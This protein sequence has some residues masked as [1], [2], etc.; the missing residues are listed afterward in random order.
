[1]N[2]DTYLT[3]PGDVRERPLF[4]RRLR[5]AL[6]DP[7]PRPWGHEPQQQAQD[8]ERNILLPELDDQWFGD[9]DDVPLLP[10]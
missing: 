9:G 6:G 1:M 2:R 3:W 10:L 7:L 5:Y 4:W 8:P